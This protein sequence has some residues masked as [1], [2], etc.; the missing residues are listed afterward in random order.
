MALDAF[1]YCDC[2]EKH[3]LRSDPPAGVIVKVEPSGEIACSVA[4]ERAWST[5]LGWK[6]SK[7]CLHDGMILL[8]HRLGTN[9]QVDL[10]RAE[11]QK[12]ATPLPLL[13]KSVLYSGT[14]TCDWIPVARLPELAEEV[15]QLA[16]ERAH[17]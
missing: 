14:H 2:Y 4:D 16:P 15:K 11:L 1:V 9:E 3:N 5:F 12:L 8:Q 6:K 13:L 17:G 10:L 7:A